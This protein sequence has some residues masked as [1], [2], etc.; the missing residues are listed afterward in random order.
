MGGAIG[1]WWSSQFRWAWGLLVNRL[2]GGHVVK[3]GFQELLWLALNH[4]S[5]LQF[6]WAISEF[7]KHW[8]E[9]KT[10][11]I[12]A[13]MFPIFHNFTTIFSKKHIFHFLNPI[14]PLFPLISQIFP[15][16]KLWHVQPCSLWQSNMASWK[17]TKHGMEVT[18]GL[19]LTGDV[20]SK[21]WTW[22]QRYVP[23]YSGTLMGR[24]HKQQCHYTLVYICK[25]YMTS[26]HA[27]CSCAQKIS[28]PK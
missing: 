17:L 13:L 8:E 25:Y 1:V 10:H 20:S 16:K 5:K 11:F 9:K 7:K 18:G 19:Q 22:Q 3:F 24:F 6:L 27:V 26:V 23:W 4:L 12:L 15:S 14:F 21:P 28:K 2:C